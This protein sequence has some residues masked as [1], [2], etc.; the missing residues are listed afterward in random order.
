M[1]FCC[2]SSFPLR[3]ICGENISTTSW[4]TKSMLMQSNNT[5]SGRKNRA[6]IW[7]H[8]STYLMAT[9][10]EIATTKRP[11]SLNKTNGIWKV[12]RSEE[13]RPSIPTRDINGRKIITNMCLDSPLL[14]GKCDDSYN[15]GT[16]SEPQYSLNWAFTDPR[17]G[18]SFKEFVSK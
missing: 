14:L 11:S 2:Y 8:F 18:P 16:E 7:S 13:R 15:L 9:L 3:S 1:I 12:E 5:F 10:G 17:T 4:P 6:A